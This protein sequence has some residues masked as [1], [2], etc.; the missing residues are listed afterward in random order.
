MTSPNRGPTA[1]DPKYTVIIG[2]SGSTDYLRDATGSQRFWP[3][4]APRGEPAP[5]VRQDCDGLHDESAPLQYL[6]L[7]CFPDRGDLMEPQDDEYDEAC[8]DED[9]EME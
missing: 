7:R 5:D 4:S 9:E 2:M 3:V 6:C 8:R 1:I